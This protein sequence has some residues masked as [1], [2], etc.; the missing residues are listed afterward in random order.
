MWSKPYRRN[1]DFDGKLELRSAPTPMT[2]EE[3]TRCGIEQQEFLRSGGHENN[4]EDPVY[5][6]GVK[7]RSCLDELPY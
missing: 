6:H 5:K 7:R 4:K 2:G 3:T 1:L